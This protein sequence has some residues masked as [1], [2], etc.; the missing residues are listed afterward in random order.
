MSLIQNVLPLLKN[1]SSLN[2]NLK[3]VD[4]KI[5][6]VIVPQL[7]ALDED[8]TDEVVASLQAVLVHPVRLMCERA[9]TDAQLMEA[10]TG[11]APAHAAASD[12]LSEYRQMLS[13]AAATAK[14]K[15][16]EKTAAKPAKAAGKN[17]MTVAAPGATLSAPEDE[18]DADAAQKA[19]GSDSTPVAEPAPVSPSATSFVLF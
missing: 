9:T 14:V 15:A 8:T 18:G 17:V 13:D 11:I 7:A 19:A 4:G 1:G 2:L 5:Q 6:V 16:A 10:I 12:Q 3:E